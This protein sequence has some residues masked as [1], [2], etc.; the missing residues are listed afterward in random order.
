MECTLSRAF[1]N[2]VFEVMGFPNGGMD[3]K[4]YVHFVLVMLFPNSKNALAY[5]P[6]T[7]AAI[8]HLFWPDFVYLFGGGGGGIAPS[9]RC[10]GRWTC[11]MWGICQATTFTTFASR[12]PMKL[13]PSYK[14]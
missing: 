2:R 4:N 11:G 3:Y 5:V 1:V 14:N 8:S 6:N 9:N 10:F 12:W 7:P 13:P